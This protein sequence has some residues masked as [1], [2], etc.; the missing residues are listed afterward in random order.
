[1]KRIWI[2]IALLTLLLGAG[3]GIS[4]FMGRVHLPVAQ[5]LHRAGELAMEEQWGPAQAFA[6][7]GQTQWQKK[8][9]VIAAIADHE[10]MD[11]ID[12]LFAQLEVYAKEED[13]LLYSAACAHLASLL[14]ALGQSHSFTWWN[15]M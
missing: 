11:E 14:E 6:N 4:G 9:P 2:G 12:A 3:A 1:M 7:R 15:L 8:W 5:D 13:A 10:P